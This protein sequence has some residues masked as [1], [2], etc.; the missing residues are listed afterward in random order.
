[1]HSQFK[2]IISRQASIYQQFRGIVECFMLKHEINQPGLAH[3]ILLLL[4]TVQR[5]LKPN[6]TNYAH[7]APCAN[8]S[9]PTKLIALILLRVHKSTQLPQIGRRGHRGGGFYQNLNVFYTQYRT[10][11]LHRT[12]FQKSLLPCKQ[13]T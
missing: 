7:T 4:H 2:M 12:P 5:P 9:G 8:L 1:M 3:F 11:L 10:F 13:K 6:Q